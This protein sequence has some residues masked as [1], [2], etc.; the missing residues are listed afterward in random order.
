VKAGKVIQNEKVL[1]LAE[2]S[3]FSGITLVTSFVLAKLVG[4]RD[5]GLFAGVVLVAYMGLSVSYATIIQ[6]LQTNSSKYGE[7]GSYKT[8]NILALLAL[9]GLV[10]VVTLAA[11]PVLTHYYGVSNHLILAGGLY[12]IVFMGF[13]FFRKWFMTTGKT[14]YLL[15]TTLLLGI[16]HIVAFVS[17]YFLSPNPASVTLIMAIAFLPSLAVQAMLYGL[18]IQFTKES[19]QDMARE[20][21]LQARWLLPA[22]VIQWWSG[23]F[24]IMT[25]GMFLG[26]AVLG[27]F[28]LVQSVF[29]IFNLLLQAYEN[30]L[31][32]KAA[33]QYLNDPEG[34]VHTIRTESVRLLGGLMV[35]LIIMAWGTYYFLRN[36]PQSSDGF[37]QTMLGMTLLY[38]VIILNYPVRILIRITGQNHLFFQGGVL[39]L[40][41]SLLV[42]R[43]FIVHW[44]ITGALA[45]LI[46]SQLLM[47]TY[48]HYHLQKNKIQLWKS[49][50]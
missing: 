30:Y 11:I 24:F 14:G 2:Q 1:F 39:S 16:S 17:I 22:S 8:F 46:G 48:W 26:S 44:G 21:I 3:I 7:D 15:L 4:V 36:D 23:N 47:M 50:T 5:F 29:G 28:R 35:L 10:S 25:A 20:N 27:M 33:R 12:C 18:K 19:I 6:P 40:V 34:S 42:F 49:F 41:F 32:P 45:G 43:Y 38:V 9:T 37:I 13:D 31:T